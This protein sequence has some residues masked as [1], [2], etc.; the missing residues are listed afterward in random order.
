MCRSVTIP[1]LSLGESDRGLNRKDLWD[2]DGEL[3]IYGTR[4]KNLRSDYDDEGEVKRH[5]ESP[6]C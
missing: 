5:T 1:V 2:N 3:Y 4:N 6:R